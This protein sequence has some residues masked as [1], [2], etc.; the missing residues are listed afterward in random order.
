[1][2]ETVNVVLGNSVGDALDT[3]DVD[4]LVGE[5]PGRVSGYPA[6]R[7]TKPSSLG[8]VLTADKVVDNIG[9]THALLNGLGVAQV[10]F[11][12]R[13]RRSLPQ[14]SSARSIP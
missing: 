14:D 9:V 12:D 4:I 2:N 11:L 1:M 6:S 3:I 7:S 5:V 8:G 10:V 13:I